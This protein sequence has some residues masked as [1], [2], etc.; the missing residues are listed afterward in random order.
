[1]L[2]ALNLNIE[3]V[4]PECI[5]PDV[6][7]S[8]KFFVAIG[9]PAAVAA[10]FFILFVSKYVYKR[11]CTAKRKDQLTAHLPAL[12]SGLIVLSRVLYL[13]ATRFALEP[14]NCV[15][16]DPPEPNGVEYM[17]GLIDVPCWQP[18][19]LQLE[20][21]PIG[22]MALGLYTVGAPVALAYF[23]RRNRESIKHDQILRAAGCGDDKL[24]NPTLYHFRRTWS[25]AYYMF[26]PGKASYWLLV[27][28]ARKLGIS[29]AAL[30]F[31]TT[32]SY[33]LAVALLVLFAAYVLQTKHQPF[34]SR[35]DRSQA[36]A[37]HR[38]K[39]LHDMVHARIESEIQ[40]AARKNFRKVR[41]V[42]ALL[43]PSAGG[44]AAAG[45]G[46]KSDAGR[47][48]AL[49][50]V[51]L[52]DYNAAEATM[53]AVA[54]CVCL[55]GLMFASDR[56][57]AS[58][59]DLY[60]AEYDGLAYVVVAL[61]ALAIAYFC[62]V[63][64]LDIAFSFN[65]VGTAQFIESCCAS[66]IGR[67][68]AIAGGRS[69]KRGKASKGGSLGRLTPADGDGSAA[70][71]ALAASGTKGAG[72]A[73][74]ATLGDEAAGPVA[75]AA[76]PMM[77]GGDSAS[78]AAMVGVSDDPSV[79]LP[80]EIANLTGPPS[81]DM[82]P[83]VKQWMS[84]TAEQTRGLKIRLAELQK[85]AIMESGATPATDSPPLGS[86]GSEAAQSAKGRRRASSS[87]KKAHF[88]PQRT[89]GKGSTARGATSP[90][91]SMQ[92]LAASGSRARKG[93]V[94]SRGSRAS[95]IVSA[96]SGSGDALSDNPL[97][98]AS[99]ASER[100]PKPAEE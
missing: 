37:E 79:G 84:A 36:L 14:L 25:Q 18:G 89:N 43:D 50:V 100:Q 41:R 83:A 85:K 40:G 12:I 57:S 7:Y 77:A 60:R 15:P 54:V 61:V 21:L 23:L 81:A 49:A 34:M 80:K 99:D 26:K 3:L 65:P 28:F 4:A 71:G 42:P 96:G 59:I 30:M 92:A 72:A 64:A 20:L 91:A 13:F 31:R 53:L 35:R 63:L 2:S 74:A 16:T 47:A 55:S 86:V 98:R 6:T 76:N 66:C 87:V 69:T 88:A 1:M 44:S 39:V 82:W 56:F 94:L 95:S 75:M 68:T 8:L 19:S 29:V 27:I 90:K 93:S 73:A 52:A 67:C 45:G 46:R 58:R 70:A 78:R 10:L 22:I 24:S 62:T 48:G 17:S 33:Q 38:A 97:R 5:V 32:P 11:F 9:L 51:R